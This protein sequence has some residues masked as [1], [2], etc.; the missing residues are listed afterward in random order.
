MSPFLRAAFPAFICLLPFLIIVMQGPSVSATLLLGAAF[1]LY[2][3]HRLGARAHWKTMALMAGVLLP[4]AALA[5]WMPDPLNELRPH[6]TILAVFYGVP[7]GMY[8]A[9]LAH[10]KDEIPAR[11]ALIVFCMAMTLVALYLTRLIGTDDFVRV[12]GAGFERNNLDDR[13]DYLGF[14]Y[15]EDLTIGIIP[16]TLFALAATIGA[17][18]PISR[19][20]IVLILGAAAVAAL[21]NF[22][23]LTRTALACSTAA[24]LLVLFLDRQEIRKTSLRRAGLFALVA[25]AALAGLLFGPSK[26]VREEVSLRTQAMSD[27]MAEADRD[28]RLDHW[29]EAVTLIADSPEGGARPSMTT[30]HWAHNLLLDTGLSTGLIGMAS[31]AIA[32]LIPIARSVAVVRARSMVSSPLF[33]MLFCQFVAVLLAMQ[34]SPPNL[35]Y[36]VFTAFFTGYIVSLPRA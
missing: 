25:L 15:T 6:Y 36:I 12:T 20:S 35:P 7:A 8:F 33:Q 32:L 29:R 9:C 17:F 3:L 11:T 34:I 21:V 16:F 26:P 13:I 18:L 22:A 31:I 2:A 27:R 19:V 1:P 5:W 23:V 4:Y 30:H 10:A 14:F 24:V 28:G